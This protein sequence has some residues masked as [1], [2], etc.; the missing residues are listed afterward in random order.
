MKI[1]IVHYAFWPVVGGVETVLLD[2]LRLFEA[3][4]HRVTVFAGVGELTE[5]SPSRLRG[6]PIGDAREALG[7]LDVVFL[8]NVCTMPFSLP[9][10]RA[11]WDASRALPDTRFVAWIHDLAASNPAYA[12]LP[13]DALEL[14][15]KENPRF[16]YVAVSDLRK[17]QFIELSGAAP[18]RCRVIPNGIDP[19]ATLRLP[20]PVASLASDLDLFGRDLVL[21]IP[22][23]LLPRKNIALGLRVLAALRKSGTDAALLITGA[24][25]PYNP[26]CAEYAG[27]LETLGRELGIEAHAV[28]LQKRFSV[29]LE[30]LAGLYR[31][32]DAVFYPSRDEGFGIPM[33]E[34]ALHRLPA[35][36]SGIEPLTGM[37]G[38]LPFPL[39]AEPLEIARF[40]MRQMGP[41]HPIHA[42]KVM[43]REFAW[44]AIWRNFLAPLLSESQNCPLK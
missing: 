28:F 11:L 33:L 22:A 13:P 35:F 19:A 16:E 30:E 34:A 27:S 31:L 23:R 24:P 4:G 38:A 37:P 9:L 44:P 39:D 5:N 29:G 40:M 18:E 14:L 3:A 2:H 26:A 6:L 17:R 25:D 42:R 21:L 36:C 7:A 8:H 10:T 41:S 1:G 20:P 15:G 32:A 12:H 43:A